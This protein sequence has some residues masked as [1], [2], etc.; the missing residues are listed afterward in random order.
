[1][2][3]GAFRIATT[4]RLQRPLDLDVYLYGPDNGPPVE[5]F[6][7]TGA[8]NVPDFNGTSFLGDWTLKV[9]DRVKKKTGTLNRWSITV[10]Y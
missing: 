10:D 1:M 2:N 9:C 4:S 3:P 6:N 8:N 7:F 5:L